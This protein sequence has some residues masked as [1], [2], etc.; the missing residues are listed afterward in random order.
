MRLNPS[1]RPAL[2][3]FDRSY[4]RKCAKGFSQSYETFTGDFSNANFSTLK[5]GQN[6]ERAIF[7]LDSDFM[8][9]KFCRPVVERW[10]DFAVTDGLKL[11]GYWQ[12]REYYQRMRFTLPALP[13]T[14][15]VKDENADRL[16]LANGTINRRLICERKGVDYEENLEELKEEQK[17]FSTKATYSGL[18]SIAKTEDGDDEDDDE[19]ENKDEL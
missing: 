6:S 14:D 7:R 17:H 5:A 9:R 1:C 19:K 2:S 18:A 10:L 8:I 4:L 3:E 11:P 13:S 16:A 12:N 15:P